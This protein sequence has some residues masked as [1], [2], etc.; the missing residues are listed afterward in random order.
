M[1]R[2]PT[3]ASPGL[4][5][6]RAQSN[7]HNFELRRGSSLVMSTDGHPER[8]MGNR[9]ASNSRERSGSFTAFHKFEKQTMNFGSGNTQ[10]N[11]NEDMD[12]DKGYTHQNLF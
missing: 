12:R 5:A 8:E 9:A 4:A 1:V 11:I 10:K 2:N 7:E 6:L 3:G